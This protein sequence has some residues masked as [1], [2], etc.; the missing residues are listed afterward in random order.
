MNIPHL[1]DTYERFID[2]YLR[3][4]IESI[5]DPPKHDCK[6]IDSKDENPNE[7]QSILGDT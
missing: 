6:Q 3:E 2:M 1:I 7:Q 4:L 5:I